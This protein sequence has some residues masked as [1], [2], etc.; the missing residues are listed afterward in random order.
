MSNEKNLIPFS[1]RT[2]DEQREIAKKGGKAS[3]RKRALKSIANRV[4]SEAPPAAV[5]TKLLELGYSADDIEEALIYILSINAL[6][7]DVPSYDRLMQAAGKDAKHEE[8]E[9]KRRELKLKEKAAAENNS[10]AALDKIS[11]AI[12]KI[13]GDE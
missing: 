2:E 11:E 7:G 9:L 12:Q 4:L 1:E 3:G 8:L 13:V 10:S 5:A 6:K